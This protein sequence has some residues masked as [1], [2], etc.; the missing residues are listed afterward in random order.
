MSTQPSILKNVFAK[1]LLNVFNILI[2]FLIMPYVY[3]LLGPENMGYI[4]YGATIFQYFGLLGLLGIYNYGL[5]EI[6]AHRNNKEKVGEIYRNLF[7]IGIVSNL[8]FL[9]IYTGFIF[10]FIANE[11]LQLVLYIYGGNFIA[12]IF[13]IEWVNEAYEKFRFITIKTIIIRLLSVIAIFL[14]IKNPSDYLFYICVLV[15][16]LLLN[17]VVS[18]F[19]A[20]KYITLDKNIFTVLKLRSYVLPLLFILV[21]NNTNILYTIADRAMLG[22]Y[23]TYE[24][25]AFY[26]LGQKIVD[27]VKALLLSI[28]FVTLPRLSFYLKEDKQ[29][30][31]TN[32]KKIMQL[33]LMLV[34]PCGIGMLMLSEQI[35]QIFAGSQYLPAIPVLRV[36][37]VRLILMAIESIL[38][39]QIIFLHRKEK[40]LV[41]L[42]LICGGLNVI[43]NFIFLRQLT[44]FVAITT[45]LATEIIFETLCLIYIKKKLH[46]T[47]GLFV[48]GNIKYVLLSLLFIPVIFALKYIVINQYLFVCLSLLTCTMLYV[49][50][51]SITKD[52]VFVEIKNRIIRRDI[53]YGKN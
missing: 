4:E 9:L 14:L 32:I 42:N 20:R 17:N 36:F 22:A 29:L 48:K 53:K 25:V 31:E 8:F 49:F 5:R 46:I 6:S 18:F 15:V 2:P 50:G 44:P 27:M 38:Y 19:Y 51:L 3:R 16:T 30:Y 10:H 26:A 13:Y 23:S 39:N 41:I 37:A 28:V 7:I 1:G 12:Q 52:A 33:I 45:T 40:I 47:T 34:L 21:L 43:L 35:V 11:R 24:N